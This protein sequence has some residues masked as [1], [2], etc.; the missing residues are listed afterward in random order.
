[1]KIENSWDKDNQIQDESF[2]NNF[3]HGCVSIMTTVVFFGI[4]AAEAGM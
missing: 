2:S 3:E 1:M 4:I